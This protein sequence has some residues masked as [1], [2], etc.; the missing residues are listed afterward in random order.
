MKICAACCIDL[1]REKYSKKQWHTKKY[2]RRCAACID[3]NQGCT[4]FDKALFQQPPR[5]EDCPICF[6]RL[7]SLGAGSKYSACCGKTICN[8][9]IHA[10]ARMDKEE[11]CPFC[12]SPS[13][14]SNEE[15]IKQV[16][17]R[18]EASDAQAMTNLGGFYD[19]GLYDL[20]Q[21]SAKAVELW[22]H[23]A[24]LGNAFAY[25]NIG[26][27]YFDGRGVE[28]DEK[29]AVH[30]Y[31]LAAMGGDILAR[32][33]LGILEKRS[34]STDR[35]LKHFMIAVE[36]GS[37]DSLEHIKQFFMNGHATKDDYEKALRVYQAYLDD[38]K[39]A[40]RDEAAAFDE[41]N[42]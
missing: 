26:Y 16:K 2:K 39:S 36:F 37:K 10:V 35:S 32:Q 7:S 23:A 29:K 33:C 40:G 1:P 31:D 28:R 27:A 38:S 14:A 9:C 13:P 30:Y 6:L 3:S 25:H 12:R 22:R 18:V 11:K 24:E 34:G 42:L 4:L 17:K 15:V 8:G 19:E 5:K 41:N 20:P 21:D